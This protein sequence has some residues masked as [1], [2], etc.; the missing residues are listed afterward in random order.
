MNSSRFAKSSMIRTVEMSKS[1][2]RPLQAVLGA[3]VPPGIWNISMG[4]IFTSQPPGVSS[5]DKMKNF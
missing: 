4:I 2:N 1:P 5:E 3:K